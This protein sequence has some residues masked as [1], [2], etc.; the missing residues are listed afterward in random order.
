MRT[1]IVAIALLTACRGGRSHAEHRDDVP[2]G[3]ASRSLVPKLPPSEEPA[4]ALTRLDG[5]VALYRERAD[6]ANLLGSLL[7]RTAVR[8]RLEDYEEAVA[9]SAAWVEHS[10][11]PSPDAWRARTR[12]L[13]R[14]H[15]FT[16]ARAALEHVKA[17][18]LHPSE[19]QELEAAIDE[20]SGHLDQSAPIREQIAHGW[21]SPTNLVSWAGSLAAQG[22]LD[23]ALAVMPKAA[24]AVRDNSPGLLAYLLF[25]WGRIYEL[26]GEPAAARELF[27]AARAPLPALEEASHL[28]QAMIATRDSAGA[29]TIV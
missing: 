3:S 4:A 16:D 9:V 17:A 23:D 2:S 15:R 13:T 18:S 1:V 5:E 29:T 26:R 11:G 10:K 21:G 27:A 22:K 28:A 20:A 12:V 25:Q 8:G 7:E 24:A 14:V 6:T 19:W